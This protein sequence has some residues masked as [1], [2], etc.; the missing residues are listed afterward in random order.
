MK[1][2]RL[3]WLAWVPWMIVGCGPTPLLPPDGGGPG[4]G[5][6][7]QTCANLPIDA[8]ACA[9]GS[10]PQY[11]CVRA[12]DGACRRSAPRC[13]TAV[14]AGADASAPSDGPGGPACGPKQCA[15]GLVCC[16][17]SCGICTPPGGLC[18][19]LACTPGPGSGG[20]CKADDDCRLYDDYCAG[21]LCRALAQSDP[22]PTCSG[23]GVQCLRQPCAGQTAVCDRG[24]CAGGPTGPH[25][26][27]GCAAGIVCTG[28]KPRPGAVL[29]TGEKGGEACSTLGQTCDP[30]DPCN[31]LLSCLAAD[32]AKTPPGCPR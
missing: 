24:K 1:R 16:N 15:A 14:D 17:A 28:W 6:S 9:D 27:L 29:C 22:K 25:W 21:C 2:Q 10:Q 31:R 3:T 7:A 4:T 20:S 26:Y 12:P 13:P 19:A 23:P 11:T 30:K 5:G 8:L 18:V 32:P